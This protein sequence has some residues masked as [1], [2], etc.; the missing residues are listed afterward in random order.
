[1][2]PINQEDFDL[3][4][5]HVAFSVVL[6]DLYVN[7]FVAYPS[8]LQETLEIYHEQ[9]NDDAH[10]RRMLVDA[11]MRQHARETF[12]GIFVA[13]GY[14]SWVCELAALLWRVET[15]FWPTLTSLVTYLE[16]AFDLG[17]Q[18]VPW[19]ERSLNTLNH[20]TAGLYLVPARLMERRLEVEFP[21]LP[22]E[23]EWT[24]LVLNDHRVF[25]SA[26]SML[27]NKLDVW[28]EFWRRFHAMTRE[29]A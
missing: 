10:K 23:G 12:H 1:M 18:A 9:L 14:R 16:D 29:A 17:D 2:E 21:R 27:R 24:G 13:P 28:V 8:I 5:E 3:A 20:D 7:K 4:R 26:E 19:V 25:V 11:E 22:G 15:D 6:S